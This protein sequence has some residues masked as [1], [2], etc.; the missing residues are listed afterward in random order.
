MPKR[1]VFFLMV[2]LVLLAT[3]FL[4]LPLMGYAQDGGAHV[5]T[6]VWV[7]TQDFSSLRSGAGDN[8]ERLTV[9]DP[10]V[11]I[12]AIGRS[13]DGRWIQVEFN[14]QRGWI[15]YAL[16][17]W[18]GDIVQLP[19]DGV[20]SAPFVRR[21]NMVAYTT[22]PTPVYRREVTPSDQIGT[23]PSGAVVEL[24]GRLGDGAFYWVQIEYQ[25]QIYWVGSWNLRIVERSPSARLFDTSYLYSYSRIMVQFE[26]DANASY[27][28]LREI[29]SIWVRLA[30]GELVTCGYVPEYVT[31]A[32]TLETDAQRETTFTSLLR[33]L[34]SANDSINSAI[35]AFADACT[36]TDDQ[37][38]ISQRELADA[39]AQIE[40][41]ER[42]LVL[43][44]S[45]I[46]PLE[47][48]DPV[49]QRFN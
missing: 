7:T 44:N 15:Y 18:S 28:R 37:F 39:L 36:R 42:N 8:F 35:S 19:I 38:V 41:A 30:S 17:V 34:A 49:L 24:V 23:I 20:E 1:N 22:R 10:A 31:M 5:N 43:L 45:F 33:T 11:T 4:T 21:L 16:L 47:Q 26:Q 32:R 46:T 2:A 14:G 29:N 6:G 27:A 48:R 9:I 12:P 25:D 40:Q 13:A 3:I